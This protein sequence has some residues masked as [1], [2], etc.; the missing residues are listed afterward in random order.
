[1]ICV[2]D[3]NQLMPDHNT[4][5]FAF[6][7]PKELERVVGFSFYPQINIRSQLEKAELEQ[8]I[9]DALGKTMLVISKDEHYSYAGA[10]SEAED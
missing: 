10:Q 9:A 8:K 5:G 7:T 1:M 3:A 4:F 6:L 2:A